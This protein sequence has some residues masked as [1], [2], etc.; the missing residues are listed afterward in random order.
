MN[1]QPISKNTLELIQKIEATMN[2]HADM[3]QEMIKSTV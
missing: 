3:M 2:V 1:K